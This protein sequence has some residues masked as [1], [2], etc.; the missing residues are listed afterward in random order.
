MEPEM[1]VWQQIK[2][3]MS[4]LLT[5]LFGT[6][7]L[8]MLYIGGRP[9][10]LILGLWIIT[11]FAWKISGAQLN[12]AITLAYMIRRDKDANHMSVTLGIAYIVIQV[13]GAFLGALTM[14][15]LAWGIRDLAPNTLGGTEGIYIFGAIMQEILGTFILVQFY[16]M[17]TDERM[18]YSKEPSINCFI[19]SSSYN[20]ARAIFNGVGNRVTTPYGACLNPAIAVGI[21]LCSIISTGP[22]VFKWFWLYPVMPFAGSIMAWAFYEFVYKKTQMMLDHTRAEHDEEV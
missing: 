11:I 2:F 21:T 9:I 19:I 1:T 20:A 4:K 13:A 6:Y 5:E 18:H 8:T 3:S 16:L 12:P 15:F 17:Q 22:K 7:L 14:T 10:G